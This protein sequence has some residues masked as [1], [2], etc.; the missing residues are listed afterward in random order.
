[1]DEL[2]RLASEAEAVE[3]AEVEA[4]KP[5]PASELQSDVEPG[6]DR[7]EAA[8]N[9][10]ESMLNIMEGGIKLLLDRR[11]TI[12]ADSKEEG[13]E[14]LGAVIDKHSLQGDGTGRVPL[15]EEVRAGFY[16]GGLLKNLIKARQALKAH[17]KQAAKQQ[18]EQAINGSQREYAP[19]QQAQPLSGQVGLRENSDVAPP[20]RHS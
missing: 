3:Q 11:L 9:R 8:Q 19:T 18:R 16:L 14:T 5:A 20:F 15:E 7:K 13:R 1:M 6:I 12:P 2:E 10:A 17:D 4:S